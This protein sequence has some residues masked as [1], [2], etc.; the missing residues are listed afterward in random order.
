MVK[1]TSTISIHG[2]N[3]CVD[4]PGEVVSSLLHEAKREKGG[5]PFKVEINGTEFKTTVVKYQGAWRLYLN[6]ETRRNAGIGAGDEVE[7][8]VTFDPEPREIAM[9]PG[10]ASA[11]MQ[12][13]AARSAF[14]KLAPSR[15]KEILSY[16]NWL[17]TD[18]ALER[19]IQKVMR[20][21][22]RESE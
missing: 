21:L 13:E 5:I 14:E 20:Q 19:N 3:P 11:L 10:F 8:E 17:K 9:P 12:N 2:I 16:L 22:T 1:F 7:I 4:V 6:T 18:A 15:Q